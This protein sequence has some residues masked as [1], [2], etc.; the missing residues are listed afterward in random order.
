M[1][2]HSQMG[3]NSEIATEAAP[4][5]V[6][7]PTCAQCGERRGTVR[8]G[9]FCSDACRAEAWRKKR[10]QSVLDFT[11]PAVP[12]P[13]LNATAPRER[14]RELGE[15]HFAL[16]ATLLPGAHGAHEV[17]GND[18]EAIGGRRFGARLGE[19]RPHLATVAGREFVPMRRGH[20]PVNNPILC[21]EVRATGASWYWLDPWAIEPAST[22]LAHYR[23]AHPE[24]A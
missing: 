6:L 22:A 15:K 16:L 23:W 18:L 4:E 12:V 11:P 21:R 3:G 19:L 10:G 7:G 24:K 1:N 20:A 2:D 13:A 8:H 5:R 14:S 17:S 9:R